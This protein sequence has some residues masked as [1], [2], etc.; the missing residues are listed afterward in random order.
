[1]SNNPKPNTLN[2]FFPT[3][4]HNS[5]QGNSQSTYTQPK[6]GTSNTSKNLLTSNINPNP[7]QPNFQHI[8]L[9]NN[10][11]NKK[12]LESNS[13]LQANTNSNQNSISKNSYQSP[14]FGG[15]E[16]N[17]KPHIIPKSNINQ[18]SPVEEILGKES[19]ST[20]KNEANFTGQ[21]T[22][23]NDAIS[24]FSPNR[25]KSDMILDDNVSPKN[26]DYFLKNLGQINNKNNVVSINNNNNN[27]YPETN[28]LKEADPGVKGNAT[29]QSEQSETTIRREKPAAGEDVRNH[30]D[31]YGRDFLAFPVDNT[32]NLK[33]QA[34]PYTHI[35]ED[36][37]RNPDD[38]A[39]Q[40]ILEHIKTQHD[41]GMIMITKDFK[42]LDPKDSNFR[43][44]MMH[45][46]GFPKSPFRNDDLDLSK[47]IGQ[48]IMRTHIM[49]ELNAER[50]DMTVQDMND[51]ETRLST[52]EEEQITNGGNSDN[53]Q[54]KSLFSEIN[55][56][57]KNAFKL[58]KVESSKTKYMQ[59]A[60]RVLC[61]QQGI[62]EKSMNELISLNEDPNGLGLP[63]KPIPH[64]L[65]K[66]E[67][68]CG[69]FNK[70]KEQA[71][72][73]VEE[74][75]ATV[76]SQNDQLKIQSDQLNTQ[77]MEMNNLRNQ[78]NTLLQFSQTIN[79]NNGEVNV[80][81]N[82][83]N[84]NDQVSNIQNNSNSFIEGTMLNDSQLRQ[85]G[86][87]NNDMNLSQANIT[88][89]DNNGQNNLINNGLQMENNNNNNS[90]FFQNESTARSRN[91][92][93]A[94]NIGQGMIGSRRKGAAV[95]KLERAATNNN[96]P[97]G[98][99][100]GRDFSQNSFT[101]TI[102]NANSGFGGSKKNR[103]G[104]K[105]RNR[106]WL[107]DSIQNHKYGTELTKAHWG[108]G[109]REDNGEYDIIIPDSVKQELYENRVITDEKEYDELKVDLRVNR[110]WLYINKINYKKNQIQTRQPTG[111][112]MWC[113]GESQTRSVQNTPEQNNNTM[114]EEQQG[115]NQIYTDN[116]PTNYNSHHNGPGHNPNQNNQN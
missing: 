4:K 41:N 62:D 39:Y 102:E 75:Q 100:G 70:Y 5:N 81:Q 111:T 12:Q 84:N 116:T 16:K 30:Q 88:Q 56:Q 79:Q 74:L 18:M 90:S 50:I 76:N 28:P 24:K 72:Y 42:L 36:M 110:S 93:T 20:K 64:R 3:N 45:Q 68:F 7:N 2:N 32:E 23:N 46:V 1:M 13:K 26:P 17:N 106:E 115:S 85:E 33:M 19:A 60:C 89:T 104:V 67:D 73:K 83:T 96:N 10:T 35:L 105:L 43:L 53:T 86:F 107:T 99:N 59:Q 6:P 69:D 114:I 92:S 52:L 55:D 34:I 98:Q 80:V 61:A 63:E 51:M 101:S 103:G 38:Q 113:R 108:A 77:I 40:Y 87:N 31:L 91:D 47:N 48:G 58:V 57:I 21:G 25:I 29:G 78:V 22:N 112:N 14:L 11:I 94:G 65:D 95:S 49:S 54:I 8:N 15:V 9:N 109:Y 27:T 66:I 44:K 37:D 71:I 82:T 97:Q